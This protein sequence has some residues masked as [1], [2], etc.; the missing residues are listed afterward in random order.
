MST[1]SYLIARG[2]IGVVHAAAPVITPYDTSAQTPIAPDK[3]VSSLYDK[4][5]SIITLLAGGLAVLY[6]IWAGV[7]YITSAGN[8]EKA[9]AARQ[10]I[11]NAIIGIVIITTAYAIIRFAT[12]IGG[13]IQRCVDGSC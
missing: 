6:L 2:F 11:I 12:T 10:A 8:P 5:V 13:T 9:K 4:S 7:Q 1:L 3:A